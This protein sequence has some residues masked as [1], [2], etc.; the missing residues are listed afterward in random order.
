MQRSIWYKAVVEAGTAVKGIAK[1]GK[2]YE[3]GTYEVVA[4]DRYKAPDGAETVC[5][6]HSDGE[7][8][9][10]SRNAIV[11]FEPYSYVFESIAD[12][13]NRSAGF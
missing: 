10:V 7:L 6:K 5:L 8:F 1:V 9:S 4:F 3:A 13:L 11:K 12:R 2:S